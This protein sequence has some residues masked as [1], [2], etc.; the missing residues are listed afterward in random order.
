MT[1]VTLST[2]VLELNKFTSTEDGRSQILMS[3]V[4]YTNK[5]LKYEDAPKCITL[6]TY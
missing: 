3:V 4:T 6:A 1:P 2:R 5:K